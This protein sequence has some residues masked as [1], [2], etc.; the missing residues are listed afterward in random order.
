MNFRFYQSPFETGL[1]GFGKV[2]GFN[3]EEAVFTGF[4]KKE[5]IA[6]SPKN[7]PDMKKTHYWRTINYISA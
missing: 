5:D 7:N 1:T 2:N 6:K 4:G 3:K